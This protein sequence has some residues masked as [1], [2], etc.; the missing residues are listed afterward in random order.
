MVAD[1]VRRHLRLFEVATGIAFIIG[2][3]IWRLPV[4]E[5]NTSPATKVRL[6]ASTI[7]IPHWAAGAKAAAG[8]ALL[9]VVFVT[10]GVGRETAGVPILV[11]Y[12][13]AIVVAL[14]LVFARVGVDRP[15]LDVFQI[16]VSRP[17]GREHAFR[18]A[19]IGALV[20]QFL[21]NITVF[22][23]VKLLPPSVFYQPEVGPPPSVVLGGFVLTAVFVGA[24]LWAWRGRMGWRA[25]AEQQREAEQDLEEA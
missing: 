14:S 17:G 24:A 1:A 15:E 7:F 10:E 20:V 21:L 2:P 6:A 5:A 9:S 18:A 23:T 11:F 4:A 8:L 25:P 19:S 16:K 22:P 13:V 3:N 12:V